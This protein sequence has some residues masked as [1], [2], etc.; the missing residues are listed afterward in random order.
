MEPGGLK[1]VQ[2]SVRIDAEI[3]LRIRS[4]PVVRRLRS[5]VD[6]ELERARIVSKDA[7]YRISVPNIDLVDPERVAERTSKALGRVRCRR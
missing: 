2:G 1:Q 6:D 5:R 4:C 7:L 3:S